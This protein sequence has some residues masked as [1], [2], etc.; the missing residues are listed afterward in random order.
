MSP[1]CSQVTKCRHKNECKGNQVG[2]VQDSNCNVHNSSCEIQS[3]RDIDLTF[4]M[5]KEIHVLTKIWSQ[6]IR[7]AINVLRWNKML[8]FSSDLDLPY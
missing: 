6:N 4:W 5:F 7:I 3:K 1:S 2:N 8:I